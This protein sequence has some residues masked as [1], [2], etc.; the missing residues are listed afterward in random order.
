MSP[1]LDFTY[2]TPKQEG[3]YSM[4]K[5]LPALTGKTYEGLGIAN[6]EMANRE[7]FRV[8]FGGKAAEDDKQ[9]VFEDLEKY[10]ELDTQGMIDILEVL[11]AK[12]R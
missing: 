11:R 3:S 5:V 8:I 2:Y 7:Y 9:K 10:C 12:A 1:F 6:G 4:K